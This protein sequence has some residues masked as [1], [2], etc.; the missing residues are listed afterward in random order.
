MARSTLGLLA[1]GHGK[2]TEEGW[3]EGGRE[4]EAKTHA[5]ISPSPY[6]YTHRGYD[7]YTPHR[8][9]VYHDYNHGPDTSVTSSWS[10]KAQELQVRCNGKGR[11][12]GEKEGGVGGGALNGVSTRSLARRL[13]FT[14]FCC[15]FPLLPALPEQAEGDA[16]LQGRPHR[17]KWYRGARFHG[18]V[19]PG[20]APQPRTAHRLHGRRHHQPR[21]AEGRREG[22]SFILLRASTLFF[23][24]RVISCGTHLFLCLPAGGSLLVPA[25]SLGAI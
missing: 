11:R 24:E 18:T 4:D 23:F 12:G 5:Y 13:I 10:R 22:V 20:H 19:G 3:K 25:A 2:A 9:I 8:S 1:F 15:F 7:V 21:G 16:W 17:Q 6:S 14:P